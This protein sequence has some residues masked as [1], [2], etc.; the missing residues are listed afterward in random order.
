MARQASKW[1]L[2][3]G[4]DEGAWVYEGEGEGEA[5]FLIS[6]YWFSGSEGIPIRVSSA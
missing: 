3:P 4:H 6:K 1:I 5:G 2:H